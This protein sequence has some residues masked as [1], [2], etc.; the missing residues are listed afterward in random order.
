MKPEVIV[1]VA[2]GLLELA[3]FAGG[4]YFAIKQMRRDLNGLG[5]KVRSMQ[6]TE[7]DR[8]LAV[9]VSLL[10]LSPEKDRQFLAEKLSEAGK[11]K[12]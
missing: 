11:G 7:D 5:L 10:L 2:I 12:R 1:Q 9:V 8:Y 3:F 4:L 6:H